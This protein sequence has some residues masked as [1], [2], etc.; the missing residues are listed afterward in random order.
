MKHEKVNR[1]GRRQVNAAVRTSEKI[2]WFEYSQQS[3]LFTFKFLFEKPEK[4]DIK[5]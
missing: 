4:I 5:K 2:V 3:T 1:L